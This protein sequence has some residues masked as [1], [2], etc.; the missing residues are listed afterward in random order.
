M[1]PIKFV[2]DRCTTAT[3]TITVRHIEVRTHSAIRL[4]ARGGGSGGAGGSRVGRS[5]GDDG[6]KGVGD[7]G[8]GGGGGGD[9]GG[10][11]HPRPGL[12]E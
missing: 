7:A 1:H 12:C 10:G 2:D 5:A 11:C 4:L 6:A 8:G 9:G 3:H